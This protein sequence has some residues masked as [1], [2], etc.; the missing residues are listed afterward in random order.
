MLDMASFFLV[1]LQQ[2]FIGLVITVRTTE[3]KDGSESSAKV[4]IHHQFLVDG[5]LLDDMQQLEVVFEELMHY[6]LKI[7][8]VRVVR[9]GAAPHTYLAQQ[10]K[11]VLRLGGLGLL[12]LFCRIDRLL[13]TEP[14]RFLLVLLIVSAEI[15]GIDISEQLVQRNGVLI[16][17]G[18]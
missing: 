9:S 14:L 15:F 13:G 1:L 12:F 10:T 11:V 7:L 3:L 18:P 16:V 4:Q 6:Q 17:F 8:Y 2:L 5:E